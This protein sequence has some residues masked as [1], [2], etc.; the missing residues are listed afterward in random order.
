MSEGG[1]MCSSHLAAHVRTRLHVRHLVVDSSCMPHR[2][3]APC[4]ACLLLPFDGRQCQ[5][6]AASCMCLACS[7]LNCV[8]LFDSMGLVSMQK[9]EKN[10]AAENAWRQQH[11]K[12]QRKRRYIIEGQTAQRNAKRAHVADA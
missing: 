11:S 9:Y 6:A 2:S 1:G 3:P 10:V 4:Y 8:R 7:L 12:E 5:H